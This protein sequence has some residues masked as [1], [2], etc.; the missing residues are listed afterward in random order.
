MEAL[1]ELAGHAGM[2][3][4][5]WSPEQ[6]EAEAKRVVER[7]RIEALF[8]EAAGYYHRVLPTKMRRE[9]Y[10]RTGGTLV[11]VRTDHLEAWFAHGVRGQGSRQVVAAVAARREG[12]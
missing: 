9:L 12:G 4:S 5:G 7:R 11:R 10:G 3:M 2:P 8:T 6:A 1:R